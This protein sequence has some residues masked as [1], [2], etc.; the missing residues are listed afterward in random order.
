MASAPQATT[1]RNTRFSGMTTKACFKCERRL[2]LSEFYRHP[3][4][5]DGHLGKCRGC[6]RTDVKANRLARSEHY[7]AYA[8]VHRGHLHLEVA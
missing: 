7:A 4:M 8:A 5:G 3:E 1:E 2:P 6:T